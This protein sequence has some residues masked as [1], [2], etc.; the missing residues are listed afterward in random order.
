[1]TAVKNDPDLMTQWFASLMFQPAAVGAYECS[2][3][4]ANPSLNGKSH[5]RWWNGVKWS[6]PIE[7]DLDDEFRAPKPE[8]YPLADAEYLPFA[9]RGFKDDPDPL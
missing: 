6:L 5:Y 4:Y 1:M 7:S 8:H 2:T 9:F 3:M